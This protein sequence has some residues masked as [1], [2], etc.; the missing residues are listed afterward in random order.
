MCFR[1]SRHP[2]IQIQTE[3]LG[4]S[5]SEI[6]ELVTL[7]LE[8]ILT[9]AAWL[10]TIR[11]KSMTGLSSILLVFEP[12]TDLMRAR[13]LVQERLN[14]AHMLP[15]VSK[16][17]VMLQPLSTTSRAMIVGLSP[18]D[19]S[20]IDAS[21]ITRW[22]ITP[23]LLG[24]P[25]VANVTAWGMRSRQLQVQVN[26]ERLARKGGEPQRRNQGRGRRHVDVAAE[27]SWRHRPPEQAAGSTRPIKG[28][29]SSMS[30]P[31]HRR[32]IL[33]R[34]PSRTRRCAWAMWPRWSRRTRC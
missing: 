19:V 28:L 4:L 9:S 32:A 18:K 30:N 10:K 5:A 23:K 15:N 7:N 13:Q 6:E 16:P 29:G 33:R 24:V 21:V 31:S 12:G 2:F 8:E 3:A 14:L 22:T 34:W 26:P 17:P 11:S 27:L 1:S 25:G 20:L